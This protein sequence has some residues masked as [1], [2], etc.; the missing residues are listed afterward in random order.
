MGM[1]N[2]KAICLL[3]FPVIQF[4][5]I[6]TFVLTKNDHLVLIYSYRIRHDT[7]TTSPAGPMV[8]I[9]GRASR[10]IRVGR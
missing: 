4:K 7:L 2:F 6:I 1:V 8:C 3:S 10:Y 5:D 9:E